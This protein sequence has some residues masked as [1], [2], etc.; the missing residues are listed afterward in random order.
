MNEKV[1][2]RQR[3]GNDEKNSEKRKSQRLK[4]E[5]EVT[6]TIISD[7]K[8]L[9]KG[10]NI[11]EHSKDISASGAKIQGNILLPVNTLV[12][13]DLTLESLHQ[14]ITALGR[15]K[16]IKIITEGDAYEAGVEFVDTPGEAIKKIEDYIS[17]K[18]QY[19]S[20]NPVAVPF[21]I[22]A[23]YNKAK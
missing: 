17:L 1:K 16:W 13:I 15:V 5:H 9:P 11:R 7:E 4:E 20:L 8:N 10:I 19:K 21:W 18:Q 22:F 14:K 12:N 23:K 3:K 6:I 2:A